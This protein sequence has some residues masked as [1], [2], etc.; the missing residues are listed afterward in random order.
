MPGGASLPQRPRRRG[1]SGSLP[2][3]S[4]RPRLSKKAACQP[5]HV[6]RTHEDRPSQRP[7]QGAGGAE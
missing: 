2:A 5:P 4:R 1:P 7:R 6:P 3:A